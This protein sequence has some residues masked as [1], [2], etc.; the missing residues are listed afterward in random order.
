MSWYLRSPTS[1]NLDQQIHVLANTFTSTTP[2]H[3][4]VHYPV[5]DGED[6]QR[7]IVDL[8]AVF[9]EELGLTLRCTSL[10]QV[11]ALKV[12]R[13]RRETLTLEDGYGRSWGVRIRSWS[14]ETVTVA[15]SN[16]YIRVILSLVEVTV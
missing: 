5:G 2:M 14:E 10:E 11:A 12:L 4:G 16:P 9:G 15:G 3:V 1:S 13:N 7:A 8:G 6:E